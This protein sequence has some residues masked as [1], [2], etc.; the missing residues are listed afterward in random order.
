[1]SHR[2]IV[3]LWARLLMYSCFQLHL[4]WNLNDPCQEVLSLFAFSIA[5]KV[6]VRLTVSDVCPW[7]CQGFSITIQGHISRAHALWYKSWTPGCVSGRSNH[8]SLPIKDAI[9]VQKGNS[10]LKRTLF[11]ISVI[12]TFIFHL[13]IWKMISWKSIYQRLN[14]LH[15]RRLI[16]VLTLLS[17]TSGII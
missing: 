7:S 15:R 9:L 16:I 13:W 3:I 14:L 5:G 11:V 4:I 8:S 17:K 1:M 12:F 2:S 6:G 10:S